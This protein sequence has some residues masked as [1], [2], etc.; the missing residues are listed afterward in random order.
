MCKEKIIVLNCHDLARGNVAAIPVRRKGDIHYMAREASK[1]AAG[2]GV[3]E[4]E[5]QCDNEPTIC[6]SCFHCCNVH[7]LRWAFES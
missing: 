6:F 2:L 5:L 3:G 7:R 1:F 4:L